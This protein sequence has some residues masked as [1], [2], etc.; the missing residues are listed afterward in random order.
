LYWYL[1]RIYG[2]TIGKKSLVNQGTTR[3]G[4]TNTRT[5]IKHQTWHT[6][7]RSNLAFGR[8]YSLHHVHPKRYR[9]RMCEPR[10]NAEH[11]NN[12]DGFADETFHDD[13]DRDR[14][15]A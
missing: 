8:M 9:S 7:W 15:S 12:V 5:L 3:S 2:E 6:G 11:V 10:E 13:V 14:T 1:I 4:A